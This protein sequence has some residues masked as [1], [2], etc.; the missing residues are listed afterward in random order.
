MHRRQAVGLLALL[1]LAASVGMAGC[2][3][4]QPYQQFEGAT[5]GT[6]YHV[7]FRPP[8]RAFDAVALQ[9]AID[10]RLE[11]LNASLST[12]RPDS[13][14]T[15]FNEAPVGQAVPADADFEHMLALSRQVHQASGGAFDPTVGAL[16]N[17]WGFGWPKPREPLT[18]LPEPAAIEAA[19]GR[20][21]AVEQ[22]AHG[23]LL[24]REPLRLD[25]SAIAKGYGVDL[26]AEVIR[27]HG[28]EHFMAEIGGEV[29]TRGQGPSGG[30][31]RIGIEAPDP[32]VSG[33]IL[34][35]VNLTEGALATSGNYRNF[36][37]LEGR[38]FSHVIDPVSGY[39]VA[40]PPVSVS[41][42]APN[43][44]LADAWATAFM[45]LDEERGLAIAEEN[46]LAVF[47]VYEDNGGRRT[48]QSSRMPPYLDMV[49]P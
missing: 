49:P 26:I 30:P 8:T 31:W 28:V 43:V 34:A 24:K 29:A 17:L 39:P 14:I 7:R 21:D 46:R 36:F 16:V 32:G 22:P 2:A 12:Y 48:R 5:M 4:E 6:R 27:S 11:A 23:Q 40:H 44:A 18:R 20:L 41:V 33:R 37:E 42:I 10:A 35:R 45:V 9:R 13:L 3:R 25:F 19:R 47:W 1:P 38:R 15:A